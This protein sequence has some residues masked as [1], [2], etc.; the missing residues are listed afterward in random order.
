LLIVCL[1]VPD[2][3]RYRLVAGGVGAF[4]GILLLTYAVTPRLT[5]GFLYSIPKNFGEHG[6]LNPASLPLAVDVTA[7]VQ[8]MIGF[9]LPPGIAVALYLIGAGAIAVATVLVARRVLSSGAPNS[10]IVTLYLALLAQPLVLPRFRNYHYMML[11]VPT[12]YIA[13]RSS[14]LRRAVP[15]L[16]LACLPVYSWIAR[17][18]HLDLLANYSQWL[19]A[20]GAWGLFIYEVSA[21]G[22]LD[23]DPAVAGAN[24]PR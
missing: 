12:Y 19:I 20:F 18:E 24:D 15:L 1:A 4:L 8:R 10:L 5:I 7:L 2:H 23:R 21:G 13:T 6:W 9:P 17:P 3:R 11:I 16:L 22:L 14:Q